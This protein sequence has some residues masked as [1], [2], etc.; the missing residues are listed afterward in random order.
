MPRN[1]RLDARAEAFLEE[2]AVVRTPG[3]R[4][5]SDDKHGSSANGTNWVERSKPGKKGSLPRYIRIVRNGLIKD[6][7]S[8]SQAT[9]LAVSA[10]KRWASGG[11]NV[12]PKVQKAAAQALAEWE[13]MKQSAHAKKDDA[14]DFQ[15]DW[16]ESSSL[17]HQDQNTTEMKGSTAMHMEHKSVGV[18]GLSVVDE[19]KGVVETIVSVTGIVDN[20]KDII[21]PGAYTKSL[22][23]RTPKGVW[24]HSW[25]T[26]VA[27]TIAVKELMPGDSDLPAN[28]PS[29]LPWPADAGALLVK[30][31]FNLG[32]QRGQE[33]YSDVT[34]FGDQQEWCADADTEILTQ[35]G[36]VRYDDLTTDDL[37]YTLDPQ[38]AVGRFEKVEA[39]NI[40]E[41]KTRTMRKIETGGHSSL[42][43]AQH[44]WPVVRTMTGGHVD[45][46]TTDTL[47]TRDQFFR[48][49]Q[50]IDA[51]IEAKYNDAFVEI[52][53][54]FW[55][56]GWVPPADHSD[57]GLYF[58]QSV[59]KNPQ[60]VAAIRSALQ[61][62]FNGHWTER[63]S[64][65]G[66]AR[67]RLTREAASHVLAVTGEHK[68]PLPEFITSLTTAQ[69]RLFI[70]KCLDG[71]GHR[72]KGGQRTWYQVEDA[73]VRAFEMICALAGVPTNTK[74]QKDYGNRHGRTPQ[75]VALLKSGMVGPLASIKTKGYGYKTGDPRT[76]STDE[77]VEHTGIVWCP[78]T[79]S[80]TW[81]ARRN[82]SI[83][84]T[85]NSIGYQVPVGGATID[86]KTG[87]RRIHTLELYEYSPV[88]F[89]AMPAA[90]TR[91]GELDGVK[92]A[93]IAFKSMSMNPVEL[94]E[95]A[96]EI[97]L[98]ITDFLEAKDGKP[99]NNKPSD[100][101]ED[102][103]DLFL[104]GD[105]ED[106]EDAADGGID[107][108]EEDDEDDTATAKRGHKS[109]YTA[110]E[111]EI[112]VKAHD[113]I[114]AVLGFGNTTDAD[115][116]SD[117]TEQKGAADPN[118]D[119]PEDSGAGGDGGADEADETSSLSD[120]V[121]NFAEVLKNNEMD[122]I[123]S[124]ASDFDDAVDGSDPDG[125]EQAG[126]AILDMIE[127]IE[128]PDSDLRE[129]FS[130]VAR[131]IA[132]LAPE[133]AGDSAA[134]T[135]SAGNDAPP[136][137][138]TDTQKKTDDAVITIE[139]KQLDALRA[140][141]LGNYRI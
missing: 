35:R 113:A 58:A 10:I 26:P 44:R 106:A 109:A 30:T 7:K 52:V 47:D 94:K 62:A 66:M 110:W 77:W 96:G 57:A 31:Q 50:R 141:L 104:A 125:A 105:E 123:E 103:D 101:N 65:D 22:N 69:L 72:A 12:S 36:W 76:P 102:E 137:D 92:S 59:D 68:Q 13:K 120:V 25:D 61:R 138:E 93:Q 42:T 90:R 79:A 33:A 80:G 108:A 132:D 115:D 131:A 6:G 134:Q 28:L 71:D 112:L 34:F 64:N 40:W 56:E 111:H 130:A 46:K 99:K 86:S 83:Y 32:T 82:G 87:Q 98:D 124:Y 14:P 135:D 54:W 16:S 122:D 97:N 67:F 20:V 126:N 5:G 19:T 117:L 45:W 2:K 89:G 107:E 29:G 127:G 129:A 73:S 24:S 75:R 18:S 37:A 60:H 128:E 133:A 21:E 43:T 74:A 100:S 3:G 4:V 39:V 140:S 84:F 15:D 116:I 88:L 136:A 81:L 23:T 119:D 48:A 85:G 38:M 118:G 41:D 17:Q 121:S 8:E 53:A 70:E 63:H 78:T 9:A 114:G 49:A 91:M 51:P 1:T 139:T 55:N 11:D 27:K 95:W